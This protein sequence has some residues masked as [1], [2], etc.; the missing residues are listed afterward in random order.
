MFENN[1][2]PGFIPH[3]STGYSGERLEEMASL[4]ASIRPGE[5]L[6]FPRFTEEVEQFV[7]RSIQV[8]ATLGNSATVKN[9]E[10]VVRK[11][12]PCVGVVFGPCLT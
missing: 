7:L 3:A 11:S 1:S 12:T 8:L 9:E 6:C 10:D 2:L 5:G 4:E